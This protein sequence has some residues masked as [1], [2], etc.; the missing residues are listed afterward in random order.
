M[1][2]R[3]TYGNGQ[4][5]NTYDTRAAAEREKRACIEWSRAHQQASPVP[6]IQ[7]MNDNGDWQTE[8]SE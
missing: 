6:R 8:A 5:S 3:C 2:Y 1:P 4:V 7:R